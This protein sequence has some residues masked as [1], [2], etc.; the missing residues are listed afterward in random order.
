MS[1]ADVRSYGRAATPG[2]PFFLGIRA[3]GQVQDVLVA[4]LLPGEA[5]P[6]HRLGGPMVTLMRDR[7]VVVCEASS[8]A[9]VAAAHP[10]E[11]V[12]VKLYESARALDPTGRKQGAM[13]PHLLQGLCPAR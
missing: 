4:P 1:L 8:S 11:R 13:L 9:A 7:A 2:G 10:S 6:I 12:Y 3:P 5:W